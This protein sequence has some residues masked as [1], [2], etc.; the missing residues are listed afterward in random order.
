MDRDDKAMPLNALRAFSAIA[1]EMSITKAAATLGTTQSSVSRHL[2][3]LEEFV[4]DKLVERSG[5]N[6]RLT[7]LGY[8]LAESITEPLDSV[9]FATNRIKKPKQTDRRIVVRSSLPTLTNFIIVPHLLEFFSEYGAV[10]DFY[11]SLIPVESEERFD[12]LLTRDLELSMP[13]D[14]W[15]L[16]DEY[17]VCA[18][19]PDRIE[20]LGNLAL[21]SMP[22]LASTSRPDLISHFMSD[23]GIKEEKIS[24][25]ATFDHHIYTVTA[26]AAGL[27]LYVGPEL[28]MRG[29]ERK[30]ELAIIPEYRFKTEM[31]YRVIALDTSPNVVL[32]RNFCKW[33]ARV[34]KSYNRPD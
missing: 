27:G 5:R 6:I 33:V 14:E 13:S 23:V 22:L 20:K 31:S 4:G 29:L 32:A 16:A 25:N 11:T 21:R 10:V 9:A 17:V 15:L 7:K 1:R 18:G 24:I 34:C 12:V 3:V 28:Y 8:L 30:G 19:R 26:A 2:A